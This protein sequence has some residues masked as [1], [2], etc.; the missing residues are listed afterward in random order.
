[1]LM[2]IAMKMQYSLSYTLNYMKN[3]NSIKPLNSFILFS[4]KSTARNRDLRS[5]QTSSIDKV[6]KDE[7]I[8]KTKNKMK[9][10]ETSM[11]QSSDIV[12]DPKKIEMIRRLNLEDE[13]FDKIKTG[14]ELRKQKRVEE[15]KK[16]N[17]DFQ[18]YNKQGNNQL[19]L[20]KDKSDVNKTRFRLGNG[21]EVLTAESLLG[22]V[23]STA[24]F[25]FP[26]SALR[27]VIDE[28]EYDMS[29]DDQAYSSSNEK[30]NNHEDISMLKQ[31]KSRDSLAKL[32][33]GKY[34][35]RE[36][37]LSPSLSPSDNPSPEERVDYFALCLAS[38]F[39]TV[40][41]YVP[42]D[43]DSKIRGHCWYDPDEEV[44]LKQFEV[45]KN[46]LDWDIEE[47]S[48]RVVW[49][50]S[51]DDKQPISG[52]H[53][54]WLGCLAGAWGC[55][56]R[57]GNK[58]MYEEAEYLIH[59]ELAR[60]A[61]A[62]KYIREES[63]LD[64]SIEKTTKLLQLSAILT[65]NVG[66]VDQGLSYW[67]TSP[68]YTNDIKKYKL[69]TDIVN[70]MMQAQTKYSK[71]AHDDISRFH[72]EFHR[73]KAIY[74]E[75]LSAEG[76]RNYPLR[77]AKCLRNS[78]DLALP[79]GPW[80]SSW[81]RLVASHPMINEEDLL[82]I[83]KQLIRGCNSQSK[84]WCVPNQIGYFRAIHGISRSTNFES[85][86]KSLD[87]ECKAFLKEHD[88]RQHL[89]L[90]EESFS[91]KLGNRAIDILETSQQLR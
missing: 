50:P 89:S 87:K 51:V 34:G 39:A 60:E 86:T 37:L 11:L 90:S 31:S 22:L 85:L 53:G 47:V 35:W 10:V 23:R 14:S 2:L 7:E 82:I 20:S 4:I 71:L 62:F 88:M 67:I 49:I 55:G 1:M 25:L 3:Y 76:H 80:L 8:T 5:I 46:A 13:R 58:Q 48:Q 24:P 72:G 77:E 59:K 69:S 42:T 28:D 15:T 79:L 66:D 91:L 9:I 57:I 75:L 52:H 63:L 30:T 73:A 12:E 54:E 21:L 36:I 64:P 32:S 17:K 33:V 41:T 61:V 16:R 6:I 38:H 45:L 84:G 70:K 27:V 81:G 29:V 74:K 40:A 68:N 56:L 83:L 44:L 65:H 26:D 18:K 78:M 19:K 43:V